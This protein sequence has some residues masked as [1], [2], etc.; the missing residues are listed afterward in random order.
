MTKPTKEQVAKARDYLSAESTI[1]SLFPD[2]DES[3]VQAKVAM[4]R[5]I[6]DL[7][8]DEEFLVRL[9]ERYMG[10]AIDSES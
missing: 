3:V 7:N 2:A 4:A 6:V 1:R 5:Q 9:A 10:S 8:K